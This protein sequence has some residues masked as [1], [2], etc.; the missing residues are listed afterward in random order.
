MKEGKLRLF[1]QTKLFLTMH[2]ARDLPSMSPSMSSR[3]TL[4]VSQLWCY[5]L[6]GDHLETFCLP[7]ATLRSQ[8]ESW[9][10]GR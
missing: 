5:S 8:L 10:S 7:Q 4:T 3:Y 9:R 1:Q 2:E 6:V